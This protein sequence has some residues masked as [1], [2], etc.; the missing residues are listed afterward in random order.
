[1]QD[2]ALSDLKENIRLK[3]DMMTLAT[4]LVPALPSSEVG[5]YIVGADALKTAQVSVQNELLTEQIDF[6][7]G[8]AGSWLGITK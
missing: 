3:R 2:Q 4:D 5:D 7:Q 8:L 6:L 1:M